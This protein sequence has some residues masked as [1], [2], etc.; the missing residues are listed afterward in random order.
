MCCDHG[1]EQRLPLVSGLNSI[2]RAPNISAE[3]CES[4]AEKCPICGP[5]GCRKS[6]NDD[7]SDP[8]VWGNPDDTA[9]APVSLTKLLPMGSLLYRRG[10]GDRWIEIPETTY[11]DE[12]ELQRLLTET[13]TLIPVEE[14]GGELQGPLMTV[15]REAS[16]AS[17][18]VDV[19][20][21]DQR[22]RPVIIEAKLR[23][24]PE[25]RREVVSQA[26]SYAAHLE[27]MSL[28][29]F[30]ETVIRPW[31]EQTTGTDQRTSVEASLSLLGYEPAVELEANLARYLEE[32]D[33][34]MFIVVDEPHKQLRKT[35]S[36]V[37]NHADFDIH[38]VEVGYFRSSDGHEVI[39]P[40]ILDAS[41]TP[42]G[43]KGSSSKTFAEIME[44]ASEEVREVDRRL[45]D[46]AE[47]ND[48][49]VRMTR[50]TRQIR[51]K[52]GIQLLGFPPTFEQVGLTLATMRRQGMDEEADE[53]QAALQAISSREVTDLEPS[54][55]C[56]DLLAHW[57]QF[58][59]EILPRYVE[60]RRGVKRRQ[61]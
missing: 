12:D 51:T 10:S 58:E 15:A 28:D 59:T 56:A 21:L 22:G 27:G 44:T 37:N 39:S 36:Y 46:L 55:S 40:R 57:D 38:L 18:S 19:L 32:G 11:Q 53:I 20:C 26:L 52:D 49:E 8:S 6:R 24:N 34:V 16:L 45:V 2:D 61:R 13:P 50:A 14:M 42:S 29:E 25:I 30:S 33:F 9:L 1:D 47:R 23:K 60:Y 5:S 54:V 48:F 31:V 17:G 43:P 7:A 4:G 41:V 3:A 35:V